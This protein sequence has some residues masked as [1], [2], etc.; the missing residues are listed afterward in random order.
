MN[1]V[2]VHL[3]L[4]AGVYSASA[5]TV[6]ILVQNSD[7]ITMLRWDDTSSSDDVEVRHLVVINTAHINLA[8]RLANDA[9]VTSRNAAI[10][11]PIDKRS[12]LAGTRVVGH[13]VGV[14]LMNVVL[15]LLSL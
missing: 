1:G 8:I 2:L 10:G 11:S 4:S 9:Y 15:A 6:C 14:R 13:L 5:W 7:Y 3:E 12:R